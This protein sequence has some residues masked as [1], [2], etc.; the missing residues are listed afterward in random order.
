MTKLVDFDG[1]KQMAE[2]EVSTPVALNSDVALECDVLDA[3]P[4][5]Q[6]KCMI[7][8]ERFKRFRMET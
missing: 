5:P 2:S 8:G 6:I 1:F 7:T 3:K 4:P